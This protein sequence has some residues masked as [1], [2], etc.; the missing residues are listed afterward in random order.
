MEMMYLILKIK[1]EKITKLKSF[2]KNRMNKTDNY[3]KL[4]F[5]IIF[6]ELSYTIT[7]YYKYID[8]IFFT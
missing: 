5:N 2:E 7:D 1:V 8:F 3:Q 6:I 4:L